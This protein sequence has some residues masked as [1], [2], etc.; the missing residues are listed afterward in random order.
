MFT[1]NGREVA[2]LH[3]RTCSNRTS[4][5][6]DPEPMTPKPPAL[7]TAAAKRQPEFQIMPACTKG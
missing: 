6:M 4:G 7:L 1:A 2:A 5:Y 3:L